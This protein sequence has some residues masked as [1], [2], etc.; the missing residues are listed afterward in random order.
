QFLAEDV[1][2]AG[3]GRAELVKIYL[4]IEVAVFGRTLVALWVARVIKAAT[5]GRPLDAAAGG[6]VVHAGDDVRQPLSARCLINIRGALLAAILGQ[7]NGNV[8]AVVRWLVEVDRGP[9]LAA[10]ELVGV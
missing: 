2:I 5:V 9:A 7:R 8:A 6:R 1:A 4:L 3:R 10:V